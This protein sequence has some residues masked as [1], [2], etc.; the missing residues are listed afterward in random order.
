MNEYT[1]DKFNSDSV[2]D[3]FENCDEKDETKLESEE[4]MNTIELI[5]VSTQ[6]KRYS[7]SK[8]MNDDK[9]EIKNE[10][11]AMNIEFKVL[12]K[13]KMKDMNLMTKIDALKSNTNVLNLDIILI[14]EIDDDDDKDVQYISSDMNQAS[15]MP[16]S[17]KKFADK[18][19]LEF[20]EMFDQYLYISFSLI[21]KFC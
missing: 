17:D 9:E 14:W 3:K 16:Q 19:K 8:K 4:H 13:N 7:S 20:Q 10:D 21:Q 1:F 5:Q 2:Y 18:N 15:L 11:N 6:F 12:L